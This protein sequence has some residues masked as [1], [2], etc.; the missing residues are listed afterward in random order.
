MRLFVDLEY[1]KEDGS[2]KVESNAPDPKEIIR[3]FLQLQVGSVDLKRPRVHDVYQIRIDVY[4]RIVD[5]YI[6][7]SNCGNNG[8]RDAIL[9]TYLE[10]TK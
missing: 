3:T 6:A 2:F 5:K 10:E 7:S 1:T 8:L 9:T 4:P